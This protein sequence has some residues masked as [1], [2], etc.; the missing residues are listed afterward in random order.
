MK[1]VLLIVLTTMTLTALGQDKYNKINY[2]KL[3]EVDGTEFVIASIENWGKMNEMKSRYLLFINT[4]NGETTQVDFPNDA[5]LEK[6]E[7]IKIDSLAI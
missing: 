4:K 1:K 5:E 3:Q 6:I 2:N 7:Q